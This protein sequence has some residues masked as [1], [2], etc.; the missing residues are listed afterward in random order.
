MTNQLEIALDYKKQLNKV[1]SDE[2]HV[3]GQALFSL[4]EGAILWF[5]GEYDASLELF[6]KALPIFIEHDLN[7]LITG[8]YNAYAMIFHNRGDFNQAISFGKKAIQLMKEKGFYWPYPWNGMI[9]TLLVKGDYQLALKYSKQILS[10]CEENHNQ[11]GVLH[12][13]RIIATI[14]Y[15]KGDF[16]NAF[17][18]VKQSLLKSEAIKDLRGQAWSLNL[19]GATF[20]QIG[21]PN[22]AI[23]YF[24]QALKLTKEFHD[25]FGGY[26]YSTRYIQANLAKALSSKGDFDQ[27]LE[28][29]QNALISAKEQESSWFDDD[30]YLMIGEILFKKGEYQ[31]ARKQLQNSLALCEKYGTPLSSSIVRYYLI[32][33]N[34]ELDSI[35]EANEYLQQLEIIGK[36]TANQRIYQQI[37]IAK[38]FILKKSP[39]AFMKAKAQEIFPQITEKKAFPLIQ[40]CLQCSIY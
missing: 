12:R 13:L 35:A 4:M 32:L 14:Y 22:R 21:N 7:V 25:D 16:E 37:Q 38:G 9:E 24:Q 1:I 10:I 26:G 31:L 3:F 5:K 2:K 39:R 19:I 6:N 11:T 40:P 20:Y 18:W 15:H 28:L 33:T 27:A 36:D 17:N 23:D 8:V 30:T 34:C 29:M